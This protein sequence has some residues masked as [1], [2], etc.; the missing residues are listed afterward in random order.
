MFTP[1]EHHH[2]VTEG[3]KV[4]WNVRN[5]RGEFCTITGA[6]RSTRDWTLQAWRA[7]LS[8]RYDAAERATRGHLVSRSGKRVGKQAS[9]LLLPGANLHHASQELLD[10][11]NVNKPTLTWREFARQLL[12]E[13][14]A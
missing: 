14:A 12:E 5:A 7:Y 3:G 11:F 2:A 13:S 8:A 1:P 9:R 4:Y 6:N 10:W